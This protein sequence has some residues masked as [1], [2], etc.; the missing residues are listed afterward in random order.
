M[1]A[2][3]IFPIILIMNCNYH[4]LGNPSLKSVDRIIMG[5]RRPGQR[6][7]RF[8]R[9]E[10]LESFLNNSELTENIKMELCNRLGLTQICVSNFFRKQSKRPR[11]LCVE[12]Y[13]KLLQGEILKYFDIYIYM[14]LRYTFYPYYIVSDGK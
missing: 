9:K 4:S 10:L 2:C 5:R 13:S 7:S 11:R 8:Q 12:A 3:D 14:C 6:L 1:Y